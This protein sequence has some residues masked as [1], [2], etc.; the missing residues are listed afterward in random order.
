MIIKPIIPIWL[1]T[2]VCIV[3]IIIIFFSD[4]KKEKIENKK[5]LAN[6]KFLIK[7]KIAD[8]TVKI[9]I[10]ILL[11]IINLRIMLPNGEAL[12]SNPN[13]NV[14]FVID[15]S[16]SMRALDY[17]GNNARIEGVINDCCNIVDE[18]VGCK[19]SI[20]TF[21][22]KARRV[23]PFTQDT[24]AVK[25]ELKSVNIQKEYY[26]EGTSINTVKDLLEN[27]LKKEYNRKDTNSK[28]IIFFVSDGEITKK[29]EKLASFSNIKKYILDGA[30]MGYGTEFGGKMLESSSMEDY[31]NS[32]KELY[33]IKYKNDKGEWVTAL[34][35]IDENNLK[36]IASNLEID[37]IKMEK[38]SNINSKL[39]SI[40]KVVEEAE[41]NE[42]K[43]RKAKDTYYYFAI[44]L[45]ILLIV[46]F[47][48]KKR[49]IV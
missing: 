25:A 49:K 22:D 44:P 42:E 9:L 3:F 40:K 33:Y 48:I 19:F 37:Y 4:F 26:A 34:S 7:N 12:A 30:V 45:V 17:N 41:T 29:N 16:V 28:F 18:L 21:S 23:I 14:L 8:L 32:D 10:I 46:N 36:K 39:K 1:M 43:I 2:L 15:T 11:F 27:T 13:V 31:E 47:I 20:I 38:S 35:K 6:K 24:N 5:T